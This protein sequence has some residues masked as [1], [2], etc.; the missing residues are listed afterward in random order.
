MVD[1]IGGLPDKNAIPTGFFRKHRLLELLGGS[2][3]GETKPK[4]TL[5]WSHPSCWRLRPWRA[6]VRGGVPVGARGAF[7]GAQRD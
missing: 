6:L 2:S 7:G 4:R 1:A 3:T 5:S